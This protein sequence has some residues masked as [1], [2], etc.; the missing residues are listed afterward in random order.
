[1]KKVIPLSIAAICLASS[2]V[3]IAS[4]TCNTPVSVNVTPSGSKTPDAVHVITT[5]T[6]SPQCGIGPS[7]QLI[8]SSD[9]TPLIKPTYLCGSNTSISL[10][11]ATCGKIELKNI[12]INAELG[13]I[14]GS[15]TYQSKNFPQKTVAK[16]GGSICQNN[17]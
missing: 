11:K 16:W 9:K 17:D 15:I 10:L 8:C 2:S 1:M 6:S 4:M 12:G 5:V 13:F 7:V 3:A 14:S